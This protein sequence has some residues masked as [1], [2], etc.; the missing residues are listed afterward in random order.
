MRQIVETVVFT[1][2]AGLG[3]VAMLLM[4][5]ASMKWIAGKIAGDG[6]LLC[7]NC[8]KPLRGLAS[9]PDIPIH[10]ETESRWCKVPRGFLPARDE[11]TEWAEWPEGIEA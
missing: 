10:V 9:A 7:K 8:G 6:Y 4:F 3:V 1:F 5:A 11:P 2:G